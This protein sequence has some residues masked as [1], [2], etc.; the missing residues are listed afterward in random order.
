MKFKVSYYDYDRAFKD[1]ASN[2]VFD[3]IPNPSQKDINNH[4]KKTIK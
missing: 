3:A 4:L 1:L 2:Q